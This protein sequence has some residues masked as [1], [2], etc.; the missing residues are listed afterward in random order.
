MMRFFRKVAVLL[1]TIMVAC[2]GMGHVAAVPIGVATWSGGGGS[3]S[4]SAAS[5]WSTLPTTSG[6]WSLVFGGTTQTTNTNNIGT[7]TLGTMSFTNDGSVGKTATFTL[8]GST[9]ALSNATII[10]SATTSGSAITDSVANAMALTG[11]NAASLGAGHNLTI[12]GNISGAGSL[13]KSGVGA[14]YL[15]GSNSQ[16]G[17]TYITDGNVRT[18]SGGAATDSNNFAFGTS[19]V[20]VSGSATIAVRNSSTV[21]NNVTIGGVGTSTTN[22]S[23]LGSFGAASQTAV[24]SGTVTMSSDATISTWGNT[25]AT[26][27]KLSLS[28]PINLGSSQLTFNQTVTDPTVRTSIDVGGAISGSGSVIVTGSA[29]VALNGASSYSG[30]TTIQSGTVS[31]GNGSALGTGSLAVNGGL[32]DLN[33]KALSIGTLSG[34][35]GGV[36]TSLVSGSASILTDSAI[37]STFGGSITNGSG[38]VSLTKSGAGGL[39]LTGSSS[40]S[41]TTYLTGGSVRTGSGGAATDSNNFAF[42]T[43]NVVVSGSATLAV[44]NSS[45][46]SNNVTIGGVGTSTSKAALMGSFGASGQ[47]A[48]VSGAVTLSS[49]ATI[50]TWSSTGLTG[51]KL[52]L[53]GP[54]NIGS[55]QLTFTQV[56]SGT[57]TRSLTDPTSW[58]TVGGAISGTGSVVVDGGA[59]VYLNGAN[60]Y[61]GPTTV[62][63]GVLGGNGSIASAVTVQNGAFLTPGS[64]VN[65][66]GALGVGSLQLDSGATAAMSISGTAA[67]LYDQVVALGNVNYGG[68]LAIDFTSGGFADFDVWQ[69][70]SGASYSGHFSSVAATGSYGSLTFN[71]LGSGEWQATGGSLGA[72][73]SLSFYE[74]NSHAIG[75]RYKAGQL[76]LVPEPSTIVFAGIGL[77]VLGWQRLA[78]RRRAAQSAV[79]SIAT[80]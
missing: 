40:Y 59:S 62:K 18:G 3:G 49:D 33:G 45:T 26:G 78:K 58:I 51:N 48:V 8:S 30:G 61:T 23:L 64:A 54:L 29:T 4:W 57:A 60:T 56:V 63:S 46:V 7:I 79:D 25:G 67:S 72:G 47:T 74:D 15:T 1:A 50:S 36:I 55:N 38:V 14:L 44:R 9:L 70:F 41:G 71:Y 6:S 31:V 12:S 75:D 37:Q 22:G 43:S 19:N 20:V 77:F 80:V 76:V 24:V 16:S 35:A 68:A 27:S 73:E 28:G 5:N 17:T 11:S 21:S 66:I 32:L 69:L 42:G 13:T 2:V 52:S 10:A 34:S 39:N 53:S 65:T